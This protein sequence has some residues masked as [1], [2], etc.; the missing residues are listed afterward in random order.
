VLR[1]KVGVGYGGGTEMPGKKRKLD[2]A[3]DGGDEEE[4]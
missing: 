4:E 2:M 1:K 3:L